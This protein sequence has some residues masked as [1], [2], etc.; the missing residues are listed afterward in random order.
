MQELDLE[1]EFSLKPDPDPELAPYVVRFLG[2]SVA[3]DDEAATD[4]IA[5]EILGHRIDLAAAIV[6]GVEQSLLLDSVCP[7]LSEFAQTAFG[8]DGCHFMQQTDEGVTKKQECSGLVYINEITID[9]DY[10]GQGIGTALMGK[11]GQ[12]VD[13]EDSI[14][15]LKAFPLSPEYGKPVPPADVERV[16]RFYERLGFVH[17]GG[18][19]MVKQANLCDNIKKRMAWR[20]DRPVKSVRAQPAKMGV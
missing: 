13:V 1:F 10:R 9:P 17:I 3:W 14:I 16:K 7:E 15:A 12:M 2:T 6:D 8:D 19:F 11:I 18:E 4:R 20:K 5:G